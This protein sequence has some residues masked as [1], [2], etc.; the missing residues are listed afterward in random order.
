MSAPQYFCPKSV[1]AVAVT[2]CRQNVCGVAL[3]PLTPNSRL[4]FDA[5]MEFDL[6]PDIEKGMDITQKNAADEIS[7]RYRGQDRLKGFNITA[8]LCGVPMPAM[9]MLLGATLL[10]GTPSNNYNGL[11][12]P[13]D[14]TKP[15]A[16]G[17][18]IDLWSFNANRNQCL[19]DGQPGL[20]YLQ[21][22]FPYTHSWEISGD[23]KFTNDAI[24]VEVTGYLEYNPNWIPTWPG[25]TFPSY[26]PGGGNPSGN[27]TYPGPTVLPPG[28]VADPWTLADQAAIQA[29]GPVAFIGTASLPTISDCAYAGV[30]SGS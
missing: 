1:K 18:Q 26:Y 15:E 29:G 5:F 14:L 10:S 24:T 9:E 16:N 12:L 27:P 6:K 3:D 8:Q 13:N 17:V 23:L 25:P 4:T 22:A 21:W 19:V 11:V 20:S 28:Q 7:V 30:D 2:I